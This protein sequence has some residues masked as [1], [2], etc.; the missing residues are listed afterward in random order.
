MTGEGV[1]PPERYQRSLE[2][3]IL[4]NHSQRSNRYQLNISLIVST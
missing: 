4:M 2:D 3:A 1:G